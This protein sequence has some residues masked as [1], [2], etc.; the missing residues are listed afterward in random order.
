MTAVALVEAVA[1]AGGVL[2]LEG[3]TLRCRL[4]DDVAHFAQEL[5][6]QKADVLA[7]VRGRGGRVATFPHCPRCA[8]YALY[9]EN[10]RGLYECMTCGLVE[11]EESTARRMV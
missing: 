3:E 5:R 1:A 2:A 7:V 8:S 9:R 10:N 6:E 4:P 11:I